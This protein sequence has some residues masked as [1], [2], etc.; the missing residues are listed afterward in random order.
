MSKTVYVFSTCLMWYMTCCW[1]ALLPSSPSRGACRVGIADVP[2][3]DRRLQYCTAVLSVV[4]LG[5]V[6]DVSSLHC[7][8]SLSF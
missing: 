3:S 7:A 1:I 8:E 2:A 6:A 5:T 4:V